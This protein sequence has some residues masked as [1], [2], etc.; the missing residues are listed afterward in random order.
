MAVGPPR[1]KTVFTS[2]PSEAKKPN[3][4]PTISGKVPLKVGVLAAKL[5]G[6]A[7]T[8][9]SQ[10]EA[11]MVRDTSN[12]LGIIL[13]VPLIAGERFSASERA[14]LP[15][16]SQGRFCLLRRVFLLRFRP[17]RPQPI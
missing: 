2:R 5:T 7:S 13:M 1:M 8:P 15:P 14:P 11:L 17:C 9:E 4:C 10:I 6:L 16:A 12:V 3:S